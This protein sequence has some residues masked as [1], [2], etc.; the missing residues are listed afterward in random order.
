MEF[1][2]YKDPTVA[3]A[4]DFV[5]T[6]GGPGGDPDELTDAAALKAF[7][8]RRHA[9]YHRPITESDLQAVRALRA[10]LREVF[11]SDQDRA[12]RVLNDLLQ[13]SDSRPR[14]TAHDGESWHLHF[15]SEDQPIQVWLG[16]YAAMGLAMVIA[17]EGFDRLKVCQ[18]DRCEDVFVD[19]SKNRSRRFCS[20]E[21][22]GNRSSVAA[23]RK[24][25]RNLAAAAGPDT[26]A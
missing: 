10:R 4:V 22:C 15:A 2:G 24:R 1:T 12:V 13:E 16:A 25:Q 20:A 19:R 17:S 21:V 8:A 26:T 23:Y 5:N 3:F 7:M 18:G 11:V 9:S 6:F 14:L